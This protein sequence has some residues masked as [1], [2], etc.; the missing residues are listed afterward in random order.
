V[1]NSN[2]A[3]GY[4]A[5]LDSGSV[6]KRRR[7]ELAVRAHPTTDTLESTFMELTG[8]RAV[9]RNVATHSN[10]PP[11]LP[12][13]T[14]R[15][16]DMSV[17]LTTPKSTTAPASVVAENVAS[18]NARWCAEWSVPLGA[19]ND[20]LAS[21]GVVL[22]VFGACSH[23]SPAA[24]KALPPNATAGG[25]SLSMSFGGMNLHQLVLGML[26]AVFVAGRQ[27]AIRVAAVAGRV[28]RGPR[29]SCSAC[30]A[31]S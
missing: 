19:S 12:N 6:S 13:T 20:A 18:P 7:A 8:Q 2:V 30:R 24:A 25:D 5:G 21:P 4:G 27:P 15:P 26:G 31:G 16:P 1:T 29:R 3:D 28:D 9:P 10:R 22:V 23:R 17:A 11:P 14:G